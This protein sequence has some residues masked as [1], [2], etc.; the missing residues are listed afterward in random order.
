M[1]KVRLGIIGFGAQGSTYAEFINSGK[2]ENIVIGGIC[3][4]DPAK[5]YKF[6]NF[7][8]MCHILIVINH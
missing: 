2:V 8:Q 5:K 6:N 4:I 3:D 1:E 7:I